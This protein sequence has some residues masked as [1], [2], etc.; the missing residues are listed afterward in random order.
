MII[1]KIEWTDSTVNFWSGCTKVSAGCAN[2]YAETLSKRSIGSYVCRSCGDR[3]VEGVGACRNCGGCI[4]ELKQ[5]IGKWGPGA[6]R[7]LHES[8]FKIAH[9]LNRKPWVCD[10]GKT[11]SP[12]RG[13]TVYNFKTIEGRCGKCFSTFHRRQVFSLS[14]GDWL[15]PE[16]PVEWLARMLDTIRV[17][18]QVTWLLLTKRPEMFKPLLGSVF[19]C[20]SGPLA[21]WVAQWS[22]GEAV[23]ANVA[24]GTSV[25]DQQRADERIPALLRIPARRRFMSCEPLL[26][27]VDFSGDRLEWLAPFKDTDAS[28][29]RTPRIDWLIIG[30]E[31]GAKARPCNVEW[32]RSLVRQGQDA[33]VKTFVKQLG[34][35]SFAGHCTCGRSDSMNCYVCGGYHLF[36]HPKGGD[37]SEWPEDLRVRESPDWRA[38]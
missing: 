30:G 16:I 28:L 31:S 5:S 21:V 3:W 2:C 25:E 32:V 7:K 6:P 8:A 12:C 9:R 4:A 19:G 24:I 14:L 15:D 26:G 33:G 22:T 37:P 13:D 38:S 34:A 29:N 11:A 10:C 1:S 27:P 20:S 35:M 23:P 17:C 36:K 18:D